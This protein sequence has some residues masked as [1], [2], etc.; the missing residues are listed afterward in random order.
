MRLEQAPDLLFTKTARAQPRNCRRDNRLSCPHPF[1][2]L[3]RSGVAADER[4][5]TVAQLDHAFVLEF[6]VRLGDGVRIDD[7]TLGKRPDA[8]Q[9]LPGAKRT[10]FN[11]VLHLLDQLQ[12]N[13]DA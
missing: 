12:I 11:G 8:G 7:E 9:L 10:G 1:R 5:C 13:R 4:A 2:R 6:S 3:L